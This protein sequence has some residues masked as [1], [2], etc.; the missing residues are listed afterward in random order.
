V[1][2]LAISLLLTKNRALSIL[3]DFSLEEPYSLSK[4]MERL[5]YRFFKLR[6]ASISSYARKLRLPPTGSTTSSSTDNAEAMRKY[7]G[8][9]GIKSPCRL[10]QAQS[11]SNFNIKGPDGTPWNMFQ[12]EPDAGPSANRQA[13]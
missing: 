9:A 11:H 1:A 2:H 5:P 12:Y 10:P 13:P 7:L 3:H 6:A 4:P 8:F